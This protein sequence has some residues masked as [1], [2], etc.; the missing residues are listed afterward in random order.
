MILRPATVVIVTVTTLLIS[1][2]GSKG[3]LAAAAATG[4]GVSTV[5]PAPSTQ[6]IVIHPVTAAGR[7]APGFSVSDGT[8][9]LDCSAGVA[10]PVAV[11]GTVLSCFPTAEFAVA[12][13]RSLERV[14]GP[15]AVLCLRDPSKPTLVRLPATGVGA[16]ALKPLQ[17]RTPE[18]IVLAD[19]L[20]CL[21]RDGGAWSRPVSQ[22][23]WDGQFYCNDGKNSVFAAAAP[24]IDETGEQWTVQL[25]ADDGSGALAT[26]PVTKAYFVA[27]AGVP[28]K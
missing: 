15:P 14:P 21:I 2:C 24:G 12:C 5:A 25:G 26:E 1:A 22:P 20:R 16:R 18:L 4:A 10:S 13:W 28:A 3:H 27:T 17:P 19:G 6:R 23:N 9:T 11:S 7:P 8:D